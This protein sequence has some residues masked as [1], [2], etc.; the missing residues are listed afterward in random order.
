MDGKFEQYAVSY[1]HC[2]S[3]VTKLTNCIHSQTRGSLSD[4]VHEDVS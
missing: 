1:I 2:Q 4:M 3:G